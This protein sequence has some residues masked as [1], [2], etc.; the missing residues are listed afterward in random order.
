MKKIAMTLC[1]LLTGLIYG[2]DIIPV[3]PSELRLRPETTFENGI[4]T[5]Y[6]YPRPEIEN[7][8][9][10]VMWK[11][12]P[13]KYAGKT[14]RI[15]AEMRTEGIAS[16]NKGQHVGAKILIT[17]INPG[18]GCTW[19]PSRILTGTH[20]KWEKVSAVCSVSGNLKSV[21]VVFGLQQAW[22][23]MEFRNPT[24]EV[25]KEKTVVS[26]PKGFKCEYSE[27]FAKL[28]PM[29]GVMSPS[30]FRITEQDIR[31][32]ARWN[33]NLIRY[34]MTDGLRNRR[35]L[36]EYDRWIDSQ[37]A[38]LESLMPVLKQHGIKVIIDMHRVPGG[39]YVRGLL[40]GTAGAA[41]AAAYGDN[42]RFLAMEEPEY[43]EAY[44]KTWR[45]IAA[46]FKDNPAVYGY[47]LMNEPD[48]VGTARWGWLE[49]Q[50]DAAKEIRKIDPETP[51]IVECNR[52]ANPN[53]FFSM[54]PLPLKN[55]VYSIHM[56][57]P[58]DY[59]HQGIGD[60]KYVADFPKSS[61]DYRSHGWNREKLKQ[62]L[63][64][65]S[66]FQKKYGARILVGEFSVVIW[67]PGAADYLNEIIGI[68]E[69]YHWD[70][71]Y[72]AFREWSGWSVEHSGTPTQ[73]RPDSN[74]DRKR[75][76]LKYLERNRQP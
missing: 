11:L 33:A 34:Q 69:E 1:L 67:A 68:F 65:V 19:F 56:Y 26:V 32:L 8:T 36:A 61:W 76:L 51:I 31:D 2:Q 64:S 71:T 13:Q 12:S 44:L 22:G 39:R 23:K 35:D 57:E 43:R 38:K 17:C 58:G 48:Q 40:L 9:V 73:M 15:S 47:D 59:T 24:I 29:R 28:P 55:I 49:L 66:D 37:L 75:I 53:A 5:V 16:D 6:I 3:P 46:R 45:K 18:G 70:W 10:G 14:I 63:K 21:G 62:L 20:P 42:G 25:L 50:Y 54:V 41:A 30:T 4:Y 60:P 72:H 27:R 52:F 7:E 74:T